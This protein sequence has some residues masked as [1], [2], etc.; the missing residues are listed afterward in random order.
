[1]AMTDLMVK[2]DWL[3]HYQYPEGMRRSFAGMAKK[4]KILKGIELADEELFKN[5]AMYEDFFRR[6]FVELRAYCEK[7]V[8]VGY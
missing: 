8:S 2:Y 1:M 5:E 4:Y 7:L 3:T 6:F